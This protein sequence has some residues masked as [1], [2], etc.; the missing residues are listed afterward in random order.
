VGVSKEPPVSSSVR[1]SNCETKTQPRSLRFAI[2]LTDHKE[3]VWE[4]VLLD[5]RLFVEIPSGIL[6]DGSKESFIRLLEYAEEELQCEHV[7]ICFAK[8]RI[9]R[10]MLV[11]TFMFLGF[12]PLAPGAELLPATVSPN[13]MYMAYTPQPDDSSECSSDND[14]ED[15]P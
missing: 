9:D 6:P 15:L 8:S 12:S 1:S 14:A 5:G 10:A 3:V 11:R 7:V 2:A 13:V 4:T